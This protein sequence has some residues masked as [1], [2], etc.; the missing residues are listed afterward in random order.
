MPKDRFRKTTRVIPEAA[1]SPGPDDHG[2][3]AT[4]QIKDRVRELRRVAAR[5]LV[6]HPKNWRRHPQVQV[7]ALRAL[8]VEVGYADALLARELPDGRLMLIDG[9]L[10]AETTP[11]AEVPVLLL[12]LT[13]EE[14]E[15]VLLTLDPLAALAESDSDRIKALLQTVRTDSPAIEE[16]LR[17]TAGDKLWELIHPLDLREAEVSP[18]RIAQ[19]VQKWATQPGQ[20]WQIGPHRIICGDATDQIAAARLWDESY[21]GFRL[22]WTDPPY[23]VD[24]AAKN[25]YLNHTDRGNRVQ[26][27]IAN[28]LPANAAG[29]FRAA[30]Q[31]ARSRALGGAACYATV[32]SGPLLPDFIDALNQSGFVFHQSLV[33]VKQ[34]FVIGLSDYQHRHELILYGWLTN[35][36]HYFTNDRTRDSVFEVDKPHVSDLHPTVKPIELIAQM[37]A[38][39]THPGELVYDPF[40]GSG[41]TVIAAHQLGRVGYGV[42][43]EPGYLA[44]ALERLSMLGLSPKLVH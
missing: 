20:L 9:H 24:Y 42:E 26:R 18:D 17:R 11:D 30:L 31:V 19:L 32:P 15:K 14:A 43:L 29:Q 3:A 12:D 34:Q 4:F 33:W 1:A 27:P 25:A 38:N 6:P 40:M 2:E 37:L 44:V 5:E 36:A 7:D 28:D 8:L 21:G 22:I 10:R 13:A 16:L 35:G 41:S 23:G 39:S